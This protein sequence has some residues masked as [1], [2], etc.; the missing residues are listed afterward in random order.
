MSL[1]VGNRRINVIVKLRKLIDIIPDLFIGCMEDVSPILV[2]IDSFNR[3][4]IDIPTNVFSFVNH[5]HLLA[6][7]VSF[8]GK[9]RT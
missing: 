1:I 4:A 5:L 2:D 6:A 7:F 3:L 8:V 9:D